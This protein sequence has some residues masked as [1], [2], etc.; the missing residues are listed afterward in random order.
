MTIVLDPT[1]FAGPCLAESCDS[2]TER[3]W[4]YIFCVDELP[5]FCRLLLKLNRRRQGRLLQNATIHIDINAVWNGQPAE[6]DRNAIGLLRLRSLLDPLH[7]LHSFKA[8]QIE[9][10]LSFSYKG[11]AIT[12][13]CK[14]CPT[15]LEIMQTAIVIL[16][17]GDEQVGQNRPTQGVSLHKSALGY[18]RSCCWLYGERD[19]IMD[20]GPFP[21]VTVGQAIHDLKVRLLARIASTCLDIGML[22]MARIYVERARCSHRF[23]GP[24]FAVLDPSQLPDSEKTV[25]AEVIHLSAR[26]CYT[27][28][29]VREALIDLYEA[30]EL[31]PLD[32]EQQSRFDA[33]VKY[34][35]EKQRKWDEAWE[36]QCEKDMKKTEG[37]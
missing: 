34:L 10:P 23:H 3:P 16:S 32:T 29:H 24:R 25:Y 1:E 14:A 26:I 8:A 37:R 19:F 4:R 30:R 35:F 36:K 15:G 12:S 5:T 18:V 13:L 17:K 22:R 20:S 27:H 2:G 21:G 11:S 31:R 33:C 6:M 28:G 7:Q 9:G